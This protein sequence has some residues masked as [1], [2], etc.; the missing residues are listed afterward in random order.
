MR[1]ERK[2][3]ICGKTFV[4][5]NRNKKTCSE[6][7]SKKLRKQ[8]RDSWLA[9]HPDYMKNYFIENRERYSRSA[10]KERRES[11]ELA[12]HDTTEKELV[13]D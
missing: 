10:R 13:G 8:S 9:K 4:A 1:F 5:Q 11:R 7:C 3:H 12:L 2:C 6:E